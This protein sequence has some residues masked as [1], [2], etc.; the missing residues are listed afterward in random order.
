ME[1]DCTQ[2]VV[3]IL[4]H[5][6]TGCDKMGVNFFHISRHNDIYCEVD[7]NKDCF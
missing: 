2:F 5:A 1:K 6:S 7:L 3:L 4:C